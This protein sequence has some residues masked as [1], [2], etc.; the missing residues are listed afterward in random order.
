MSGTHQRDRDLRGRILLKRLHAGRN[1]LSN[2]AREDSDLCLAPPGS[3]QHRIAA[4]RRTKI[5]FLP[6]ELPHLKIEPTAVG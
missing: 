4:E 5:G 6:G 2:I 3:F 1:G